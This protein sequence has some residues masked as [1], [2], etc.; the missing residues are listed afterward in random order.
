MYSAT[1]AHERSIADQIKQS[2]ENVSQKNS[3][4]NKITVFLL[5]VSFLFGLQYS[6]SNLYYMN[7]VFSCRGI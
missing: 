4:Q 1:P 6:S 7:P 3:F 2:V 5:L